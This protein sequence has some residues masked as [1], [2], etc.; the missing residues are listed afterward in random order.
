M[1][2]SQ[3]KNELLKLNAFITSWELKDN[4][5]AVINV[6]HTVADLQTKIIGSDKKSEQLASKP[7]DAQQCLAGYVKFFLMERWSGRTLKSQ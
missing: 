2:S 4:A 7:R 3:K 6:E 5:G 1:A